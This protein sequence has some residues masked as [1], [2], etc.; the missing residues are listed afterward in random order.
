[1]KISIRRPVSTSSIFLLITSVVLVSACGRN[2]V[3]DRFEQGNRINDLDLSSCSIAQDE[4]RIGAGID[5]IPALTDPL[6]LE[7]DAAGYLNSENRVIGIEVGTKAVAVPLKIL[8]WHEIV[9]MEMEGVRFAV[10][11]CPLTGSGIVFDRSDVFGASFGVSGLLMKN[12]LIMYDRRSNE[13][14]W[15]QMAQQS[16]CG[17]ADG[18][19][20]FTLPAV[21]ISWEGWRSLH[22]ET[23]VLSDN[24]GF[25][26]DYNFYPYGNYRDP[27]NETLIYD[28]PIDRRLPPKEPVL[29][30]PSGTGGLAFPYSALDQGGA[31]NVV[32]AVDTTPIVVF[33]NRAYRVAMAYWL[34]ENSG[35]LTF[36][37]RGDTIVDVETGSEWRID[38]CS[39]VGPQRGRRLEPVRDAF[40]AYWFGWAAFYPDTDIWSGP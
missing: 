30:I 1:M 21:E 14:L 32:E 12:N 31:V 33:W 26:R 6:L 34:P 38:G 2:L 4:V 28:M 39:I 40:V 20:L 36:E 17:L 8:W 3:D 11:Y 35:P 29:G 7:A 37:V 23:S 24:T 5:R 15:P 27:D 13:S 19:R 9:N 25:D 18:Q 10:T 22:P 16:Q